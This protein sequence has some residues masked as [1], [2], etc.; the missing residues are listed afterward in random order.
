VPE[1]D[2]AP[3]PA[4]VLAR[5]TELFNSDRSGDRLHAMEM[6]SAKRGGAVVRKLDD[7]AVVPLLLEGLGDGD[8]RVRRAAARGLRPWIA[9]DPALLDAA[10]RVYAADA[11]DGRYSHA[12]LLDTRGGRIWIPR[13]AVVKGH[14][15]LLPDANTDRYFRFDFFIPGQAPAWTDGGAHCGHLVLYFVPE[16]SYSRQQLVATHDE[17]RA[18]ANEREQSRYAGDVIDFYRRVRLAYGVRVHAVTGGGGLRRSRELDVDE[19]AA[20]EGGP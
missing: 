15:A 3:A 10:L 2:R 20:A 13:I 5:I 7:P 16:W 6:I 18:K 1:S 8:L 14:A 17:R 9:A 11:F 19:I 12:G 4:T